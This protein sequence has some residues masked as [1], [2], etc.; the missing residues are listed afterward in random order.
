MKGQK[1]IKAD[2]K[3]QRNIIDE[4]NDVCLWEHED[5][6]KREEREFRRI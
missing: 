3:R 4:I 1:N 6:V 2:M 5:S